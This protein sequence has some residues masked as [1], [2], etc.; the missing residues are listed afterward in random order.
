MNTPSSSPAWAPDACTLPTTEQPLRI[1]E[2]DDVFSELTSLD[3]LSPVHVRMHL[4]G[5]AGLEDT[6]RDLVARETECCSFFT[7]T[8]TPAAD[9]PSGQLTLDVAA[10]RRT[11]PSAGGAGRT[12][13]DHRRTQEGTLMN[14]MSRDDLLA[15]LDQPGMC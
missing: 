10:P 2:F 12:R 14:A 11:H 8:L 4:A 6:V 7:F 3:R 5:A 9:A 1:G 15:A 13:G